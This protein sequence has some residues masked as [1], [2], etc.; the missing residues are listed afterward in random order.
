M[1]TEHIELISNNRNRLK[2]IQQNVSLVKNGNLSRVRQ[3][4][5]VTK[6]LINTRWVYF[7]T[8]PDKMSL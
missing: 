6:L 1:L 4:S 3:L 8:L 2:F 7:L 5:Q